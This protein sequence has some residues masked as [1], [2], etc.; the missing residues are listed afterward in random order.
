MGLNNPYD[1]NSRLAVTT[2]GYE[3]RNI[4]LMQLSVEIARDI[5][6]LGHIALGKQTYWEL[7]RIRRREGISFPPGG[8]KEA[9]DEKWS[10]F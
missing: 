9:W 8:I 7:A 2:V 10:V 3:G 4:I 6:R 1:S 5:Q